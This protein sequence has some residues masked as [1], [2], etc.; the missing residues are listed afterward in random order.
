[1]GRLRAR[2]A[3][4]NPHKLDEL[5]TALT[6]WT[7]ELLGAAEFPPE[8]GGSYLDNARAKARF[9]RVVAPPR[10]PSVAALRC[11]ARTS[12]TM[13]VIGVSGNACWISRT[14]KLCSSA[15]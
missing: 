8:T 15:P 3:S 10:R 6:G 4:Q 2:L 11:T 12:R 14:R 9:G 7:V 5:R 1:M 13:S